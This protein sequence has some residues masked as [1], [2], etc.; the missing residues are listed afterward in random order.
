MQ[1]TGPEQM[2]LDALKAFPP[3]SVYAGASKKTVFR[4][5]QLYTDGRVK[6]IAWEK[7]RREL[8]VRI[9]DGTLHL[10]R[11]FLDNSNLV[12]RCACSSYGSEE[13][14]VH[15]VCALLM[16]VHLLKP[17]LFKMNREDPR[18]RDYLL[19]GLF[20]QPGRREAV[21]YLGEK[22]IP[23]SFLQK[24][25][26]GVSEA[27]KLKKGHEFRIVLEEGKG[28][29]K[30]FI[31]KDGERLK[32]SINSMSLPAELRYIM[33]FSHREDMSVPLSIF[34]KRGNDAY[35]IFY[36][37]GKGIRRVEWVEDISCA[38]WTEF[39]ASGSEI[40][41]KKGCAMGEDQ[42]PA[43]IIGSFAFNK[44]RTKMCYVKERHG[45]VLW[46]IIRNACHQNPLVAG[47]INETKE[48]TI[49]I[50]KKVFRNF[51]I[52]FNKPVEGDEM[53]PVIYR[54]NGT[55]VAPV[56]TAVSS[57]RLAITQERDNE[58]EFLIRPECRAGD[59]SFSPSKKITSFVKTVEWGQIPLSLRS[60]K[61]KPLLFDAFFHGLT[62]KN[63]KV[64]DEAL[65]KTINEE[66]FGKPKLATMA[67]RLIRGA[68]AKLK[69]GEMQLHFADEQWQLISPDRGK[70]V[71]LFF[72][73]YKV[74]GARLFE[75]II[76]NDAEMKVGR[77]EFLAHLYTLQ[78]MADTHGIELYLD[79]RPI[80]IAAW[81]FE[82][83]ATKGTIDWFEIRPEIRCK[84]QAIG[85]ELWEQALARKGI[86]YQDGVVQVLDEKTLHTLSIITRL[87]EAS[88][89]ASRE[90]V[91]VPRLRIIE[92][93][94][95]RNQ[96]IKVKFTPRD[97]A[98]MARLTQFDRI[99]EKSIPGELRAELRHY[100]K[101]GYYWLSFLYE[102]RFGA[103][104]ADDMGLGKTIQAITL[105]GAIREGIVAGHG[106]ALNPSLIVVPPSLIFNWEQEIERFYPALKVYVYGGKARSVAFDGYDV[107]LTSY[108]L[109]RRD[110]GKLKKLPFNIVIFDEAQA[111][112]NIFANTTGAVRQLKGYFK[113][114]LTG[115]PVENHIGE[116]FSIMDLVLPGLLGEY[117]EFQGQAKQDLSSFLPI[118]T[119][120]TK[121]FVLRRTKERILKELPPKV[122]H[123][124]YL[125][126]T[127]KQKKFYN[128]TVEEVKTTIED[129][130]KSK[131]G[132]QA[133]IIALTAI[134]K[135]RQICLTPQLL[136]PDLKEVSPKIEFLIDKLEELSSELHSS[137]I[138]SQFTSFLDIVERE[139]RKKGF[140]VFRL[141]GS[142]PVIKR[143]E[144][145][146][147]FQCS[148]GPAVFLLSLKAGG[149]GLNL[150]RATYVFHLD[151]WWNP[152]VENQ[153]SDRSHRIGQKKKVIVTRLLMR[154]TVEEKMMALKQRK[155]SLYRALMDA[156]E[157]SAGK[158]ITREDFNFLLGLD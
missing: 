74:F 95:L 45:W 60:R 91:S 103:C 141:D 83:D 142:T 28:S 147:G 93:F 64:L 69:A 79:G 42:S 16:I 133:K 3:N 119:E 156:P 29:L 54:I 99:D 146:E 55:D 81:E 30:V 98:I 15:I 89:T 66:T 6:D 155:L 34:L 150:T 27:G 120:R 14:C 94:S 131:T 116:Y 51:Q 5:F 124:V 140:H 19:A 11:V 58:D 115:T 75:R 149:Q 2:L 136:V 78:H 123:D 8:V 17:N 85:R 96:G 48:R 117:R 44:E 151:P 143:R 82:L 92:L 113:V 90:I 31:E 47:Y 118:V 10:V 88:K 158:S 157:K 61:R 97:E 32:G 122:E 71:L 39:D 23:F 36:Q 138:F 111:I 130:Y 25:R 139:V 100:Q 33:N 12:F 132:S 105:L 128:K 18:Y 13:N 65:K 50:P 26:L 37:D 1:L 109:I 77:E 38:T 43:D 40:C 73:P 22:V 154:H 49:H 57:Y 84:G 52:S 46:D 110:I 108:G 62:L 87:S 4:G 107:I 135:L 126:L 59:Y 134:M 53:S 106:S 121:P 104:L 72:I 76:L 35:P 70:E 7:G 41:L 21:H 102:H 56:N 144:I 68:V 67:R 127:E 137:L 145:V 63:R 125:E 148:E 20:K 80:E 112:K 9:A 152:A 86:I 129:A 153:A 101:E 114:A 24:R